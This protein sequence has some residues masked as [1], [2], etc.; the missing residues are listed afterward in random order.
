MGLNGNGFVRDMDL[1]NDDYFSEH[2]N[3]LM[4]TG[5]SRRLIKLSNIIGEFYS[6]CDYVLYGNKRCFLYNRKILIRNRSNL[7]YLVL[8]VDSDKNISSTKMF[9]TYESY[10][11]Y[12]KKRL[13]C[14]L[15]LY[16]NL[17]GT[18]L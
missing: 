8:N 17:R 18:K 4:K 10:E 5:Y 1:Y 11:S 15:R 9:E 16:G 12:V 6:E 14:K 2:Y 7:I 13:E 3:S